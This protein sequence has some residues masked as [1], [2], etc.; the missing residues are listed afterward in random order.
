MS[1]YLLIASETLIVPNAEGG[2]LVRSI[3]F[4]VKV[5]NQVSRWFSEKWRRSTLSLSSN[6]HNHCLFR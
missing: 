4:I 2:E 3:M 6:F 1:E 5:G